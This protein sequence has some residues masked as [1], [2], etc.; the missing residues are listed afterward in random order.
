MSI[1]NDTLIG[2]K[3]LRSAL[4][5]PTFVWG[6]TRFPCAPSSLRRG[7]TVIVGG[8]EVEISLTL[9]VEKSALPGKPAEGN[10]KFVYNGKTYRVLS[11]TESASGSHY[12][13]DLG[14]PNR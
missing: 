14:D 11:V 3:C 6:A 13:I 5:N 7:L 2:L 1:S 12:E 10:T 9:F 8:A 4:G